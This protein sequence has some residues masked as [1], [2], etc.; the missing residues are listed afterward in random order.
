MSA[1]DRSAP[2][3]P[4]AFATRVALDWAYAHVHQHQCTRQHIAP[5]Q[6]PD[7]LRRSACLGIIPSS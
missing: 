4:G 3:Q 2:P 7:P 1:F 6:S 5:W